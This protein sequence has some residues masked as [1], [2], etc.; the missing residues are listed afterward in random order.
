MNRTELIAHLYRHP[1]HAP[2]FPASHDF[3]LVSTADIDARHRRMHAQL[4]SGRGYHDKAD[5]SCPVRRHVHGDPSLECTIP[6]CRYPHVRFLCS[7][8]LTD[9]TCCVLPA[10]HAGDDHENEH[11]VLLQALRTGTDGLTDSEREEY[12]MQF[13]RTANAPLTGR[14]PHRAQRGDDVE[15]WLK[16]WRDEFLHPADEFNRAVWGAL[17]DLLDDYRLHADT[18]MPLSGEVRERDAG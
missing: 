1:D 16:R 14:I 2:H 4:I 3:A 7:V 15:A 6:D 11:G 18:G 5:I 8:R 12:A 17:D 10:D 13:F 9:G